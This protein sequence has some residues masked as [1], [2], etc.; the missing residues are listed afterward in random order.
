MKDDRGRQIVLQSAF[1][2]SCAK[3]V[4]ILYQTAIVS[5]LF[6]FFLTFF[7]GNLSFK[8]KWRCLNCT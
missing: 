5:S 7:I 8:S 3:I 6:S 1:L 4:Y 2:S